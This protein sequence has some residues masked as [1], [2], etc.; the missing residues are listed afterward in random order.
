[1]SNENPQLATPL[2]RAR[3][4]GSARDGAHHW[5]MLRVT[6]LALVFLTIWFVI[7]V[8]SLKGVDRLHVVNFF[9]SPVN[10]I[11]M[12]LLV[13]MSFYHAALGIQVV[14]EDYIHCKIKKFTTLMLVNS[15]LF[16]GGLA[17]L[18]AIAKMHF[19]S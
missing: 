17:T 19:A 2:K 5:I 6:S 9:L 16:V 15:L 13:I 18:M 1:M 11:L 7:T 4:L 14:I 10:S 12:A 8:I 3:N